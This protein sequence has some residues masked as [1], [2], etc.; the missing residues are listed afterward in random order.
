MAAALSKHSAW[1]RIF[2]GVLRVVAVRLSGFGCPVVTVEFVSA[3]LV[4]GADFLGFGA[5]PVGESSAPLGA[6]RRRGS[7][8]ELLGEA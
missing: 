6:T 1:L 8:H 3:P 5:H 2:R 4:C 7:C